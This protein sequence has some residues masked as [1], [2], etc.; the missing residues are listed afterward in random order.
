M[1]P[2]IVRRPKAKRDVV[3]IA[4]YLSERSLEASD[5]FVDAVERAFR[6]LAGMPG[7]GSPRRFRKP[8]FTGLRMWPVQGFDNYLVFYR[9]LEDGI[10]VVRVLHAARDID[11]ILGS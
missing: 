11:R 10:E 6:S 1:N 8:Q 2:R 5:R 7:M 3:E 4:L 9:P